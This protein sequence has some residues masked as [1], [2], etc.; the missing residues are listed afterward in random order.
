[1]SWRLN[2]IGSGHRMLIVP[3]NTSAIAV[4]VARILQRL[5]ILAE[6][7]GADF[8][9][10]GSCFQFREQVHVLL[11]MGEP[12]HTR[13]ENKNICEIGLNAGHSAALMLSRQRSTVLHSFDTMS[14][15]YS[16][17]AVEALK[18][19]YPGRLHLHAGDSAEVVGAWL[20]VRH[21]QA[22]ASLSMAATT[23][24]GPTAAAWP[25]CD[26]FFVDGSH[27]EPWVSVDFANAVR[28]TRAGGYLMADDTTFRFYYVKL[29]WL[30]LIKRG[31]LAE[32]RCIEVNHPPPIGQR[33]FCVAVRTES[34]LR[35]G[36][37]AALAGSLL[38]THRKY[39]ACLDEPDI[40]A[41][42][43]I[44][45]ET[46]KPWDPIEYAASCELLRRWR[47][48]G[49]VK[50]RGGGAAAGDV[51]SGSNGGSIL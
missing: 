37:A 19:F 25:P 4:D 27:D 15:A 1:M 34:P 2:A 45:P 7:H 6:A 16:A 41:S 42:A 11:Q 38:R 21:H 8:K 36:S 40:P 17:A 10:M 51:P 47:R 29:I 23:S 43:L 31:Y 24:R 3:D 48:A 9:S 44:N 12:D 35:G 13:H 32:S 14:N 30:E 28:G 18:N 39:K 22:A 46:G 49:I 20:D 33:G 50:V 5:R 26:R